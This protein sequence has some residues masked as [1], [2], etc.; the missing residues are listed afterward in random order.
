[1]LVIEVLGALL[2]GLVA[3]QLGLFCLSSF[4]RL[5]SEQQKDNLSLQLLRQR[6]ETAAFQRQEK[7]QQGHL[8]EGWRKFVVQ[9]KVQECRDTCSFYLAAYDKKPLPPFL[10]GQYLTFRLPIPGEPRPIVRC[11]SLSDSP[12]P[13]Y[14]RVTIKK[15]P[16]PAG[17]PDCR[18]G[19]ASSFFHDQLKEGDVLDVQAPRGQFT[20]DLARP[21][22]V[23]LIAGGVGLTP[24]LCM[25]NALATRGM[26]R[27]TW[28]FYG[29]RNRGD[30]VMKDHLRQ[31]ARQY[32]QFHLRV[33]YSN[34]T[35]EDVQG[36]DYDHGQRVSLDLLKADLPSNNYEFY[37]CGPPP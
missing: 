22:P 32:P 36:T 37:V 5:V 10:P 15:V 24:L 11:Y 13:E 18:P 7:E 17:K 3:F 6:V 21:A 26:S 1:V 19:L 27:E 33:C 12:R 20:L 30:H 28:L 16:P 29:V 9:R 23:A 35:A 14:Y 31:L 2:I 8:W 34:P 25:A 4:R